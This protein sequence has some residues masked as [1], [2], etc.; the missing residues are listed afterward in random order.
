YDAVLFAT[1]PPAGR[2]YTYRSFYQQLSN[3]VFDIQG[4]TYGY[5]T[6]DSNEVY[7][8]GGTSAGCQ[9]Q[10][11]YNSTNCNGLF[12]SLPFSRQQTALTKALDKLDA[13]IAF[14]PCLD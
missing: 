10:N 1:T 9:A 6:L 11:P 12:N 8:T 2:S 4:K 7:Y 14:A 13:K 3:G 5:A